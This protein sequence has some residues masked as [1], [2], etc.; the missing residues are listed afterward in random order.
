MNQ[1]T[2]EQQVAAL[3]AAA[4]S[5]DAEERSGGLSAAVV[6]SLSRATGCDYPTVAWALGR[7]DVAALFDLPYAEPPTTV[8]VI[9][10]CRVLDPDAETR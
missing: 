2:E 6:R 8:T 5:G 1:L 4:R 3:V 10:D 7:R 9:G